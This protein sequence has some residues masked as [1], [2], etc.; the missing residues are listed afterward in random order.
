MNIHINFGQECPNDGI[1]KTLVHELL[2]G[3][4][5]LITLYKKKQLERNMKKNLGFLITNNFLNK[6]QA[7]DI[8]NY[9]LQNDIKLSSPFGKQ[10]LKYYN[11]IYYANAE[12]LSKDALLKKGDMGYPTAYLFD[13]LEK[14]RP[15][16]MKRLKANVQKL[17]DPRYAYAAYRHESQGGLPPKK[18]TQSLMKKFGINTRGNIK[19]KYGKIDHEKR[20]VEYYTNLSNL[21]LHLQKGYIER[22]VTRQYNRYTPNIRLLNYERESKKKYFIDAM[23]NTARKKQFL[24][25]YI[26]SK[27]W[28]I[29][30]VEFDDSLYKKYLA[31]CY[32]QFVSNHK[33][34]SDL[35]PSLQIVYNILRP[36]EQETYQQGDIIDTPYGSFNYSDFNGSVS[37]N[38]KEIQDYFESNIDDSRKSRAKELFNGILKN[39]FNIQNG[40][41][42]TTLNYYKFKSLFREIADGARL[43]QYDSTGTKDYERMFDYLALKLL[44]K[45][46]KQLKIPIPVEM[47]GKLFYRTK[48]DMRNESPY[49]KELYG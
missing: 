29:K 26:H 30:K 40:K 27:G 44:Q 34:A 32:K 43:N 24:F 4:Q 21:I 39:H 5:S 12:L 31:E 48:N 19:D 28:H 46:Q 3:I 49:K 7:D 8:L 18:L 14:L 47:L 22:V 16:L 6:Q 41:Y 45:F 35:L 2:H 23:K 25:D 11:M 17:G 15:N 37:I 42:K 33:F 20:P 9:A 13:Q 1:Y 10:L 36:I 38:S